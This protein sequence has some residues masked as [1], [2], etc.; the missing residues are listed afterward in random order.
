VSD[1]KILD[2]YIL[3]EFSKMVAIG[4]LAFVVIFITLNMVEKVDDFIDNDVPAHTVA[5]YYALQVPY[6]F[7]LTLP[8][9]VLISA[10]FTIGQ[11][12][13]RNELVAIRASGI[14]FARTMVPMVAGG[15]VASLASLAV[16]E[17]VQP[18]AS[19]V[20]RSIETG[21]MRK[22]SA[23]GGPRIRT[24]ITYR[25]K[26]GLVYS[27]PEYDTKL[28]TMRDLVVERSQESR[29]IFR[30]NAAKATWEDS[31][32]VLSDARVRWFSEDG[33]V[34]SETY[35][36]RGPLEALRDYP[37]DI[38]REQKDPEEM[39]YRELRRLVQRIDES[40]GDPARYRVGLA[41][42]LSFPFSSLIVVLI[43]AP[44]TAHLRRGG[45]AVGVG[46]GLGLAFVYYGFM[47]GGQALG[48]HGSLPP[49]VA[50]WAGNVIFAVCGVLLTLKAEKT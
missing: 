2:R 47:K 5:K 35:I 31:V 26:D 27:T 13:R 44:L 33:E 1:L 40:G 41:M 25:G 37:R 6:I 34:K 24:N 42:K 50:A 14:R 36:A 39:S 38:L 18:H 30:V 17:F 29:L 23:S 16:A 4:V 32:W 28:N 48:D 8:V 20:V 46:I 22:G 10:L 43:G 49:L 11:M 3:R 45:L 12:A 7:T 21:E 19:V 15:L 9:A